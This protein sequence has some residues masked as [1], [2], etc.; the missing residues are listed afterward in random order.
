MRKSDR[1]DD[2]SESEDSSNSEKLKNI[3][4]SF[5][6]VSPERFKEIN[7]IINK[8]VKDRGA[9]SKKFITMTKINNF[10]DRLNTIDP[11]KGLDEEINNMYNDVITEFNTLINIMGSDGSPD[12]RERM[13]NNMALVKDVF[14]GGKPKPSDYFEINN[15]SKKES[16]KLD[17][18]TGGEGMSELESKDEKLKKEAKEEAEKII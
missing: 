12:S 7:E 15:L 9:I 5:L 4:P 3:I 8:E 14:T 17:T 13:F 18:T 10:Y 11:T 1:T 16:E 2:S 6:K